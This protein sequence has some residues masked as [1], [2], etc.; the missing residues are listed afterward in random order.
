M[1]TTTATANSE[2][3]RTEADNPSGSTKNLPP[4]ED[5]PKEGGED[6]AASLKY[7]LLGPSLLKAGQDT[8][9]QSKVSEII[10]EA[11][12][13]SKFFN[14]EEARDKSLTAKIDQILH[15]KR[16][17]VKLDLGHELRVA[18]SLIA[19][20]ELSRDLSQYIVHVDCDAFYA[21]MSLNVISP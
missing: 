14:R 15:K 5:H 16:Q 6:A 12:R 4:P 18:D 8:V 7:S 13:G 1:T 9:D 19:Q 11:S 21:C 2:M 10:Y 17:L 20:L 3:S